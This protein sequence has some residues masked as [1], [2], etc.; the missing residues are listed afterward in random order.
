[1]KRIND[2]NVNNCPATVLNGCCCLHQSR[3]QNEHG[4]VYV[5]VERH[6]K[7]Q[8]NTKSA[9]ERTAASGHSLQTRAQFVMQQSL[10]NVPV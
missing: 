2:R 8:I 5:T 6:V 7:Q 4:H 1:M 9:K 3:K 10:T